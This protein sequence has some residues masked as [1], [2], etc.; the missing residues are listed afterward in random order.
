MY[1]IKKH[2]LLVLFMIVS[3]I[4][5]EAI[6]KSGLLV[7]VKKNDCDWCSVNVENKIG[8]KFTFLVLVGGCPTNGIKTLEVKSIRMTII[9][10]STNRNEIIYYDANKSTHHS[11]NTYFAITR[12]Y[13]SGNYSYRIDYMYKGWFRFWKKG[14]EDSISVDPK[15]EGDIS[16]VKSNFCEGETGMLTNSTIR[17]GEK[18][19]YDYY[20]QNNLGS[21]VLI[22]S[23]P[24]GGNVSPLDDLQYLFNDWNT[25]YFFNPGEYKVVVRVSNS[26]DNKNFELLFTI[27]PIILK[28]PIIT[29]NHKDTS[30]IGSYT[31]HNICN[32]K[33]NDGVLLRVNRSIPLN[34]CE[35]IDEKISI[36]ISAFDIITGN[37]SNT[38]SIVYNFPYGNLTFVK[39]KD[40]FPTY[41]FSN[42][43]TYKM[44]ISGQ[45]YYLRMKSWN[46]CLSVSNPRLNPRTNLNRI[47]N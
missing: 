7:E 15:I 16:L 27:N 36:S 1:K 24:I 29:F 39:L 30:L 47:G 45:T 35:R 38:Q 14:C 37:S 40:I 19:V 31:I 25:G 46:D 43:I 4:E 33:N 20:K 17:N 18:Y 10:N 13:S 44:I 9:D 23:L 34:E 21:W 5:A 28:S 3:F 11:D 22:K 8:D 2:T 32:S 6:N 41:N 26:N 12:P 42:N